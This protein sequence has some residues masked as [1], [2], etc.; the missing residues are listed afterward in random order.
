MKGIQ[1]SQQFHMA[2]HFN[3]HITQQGTLNTYLTS[4]REYAI[5]LGFEPKSLWL[6]SLL[7]SFYANVHLPFFIG[8]TEQKGIQIWAMAFLGSEF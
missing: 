6:Q 1:S 3:V 8:E 7:H 2:W 5:E 4:L